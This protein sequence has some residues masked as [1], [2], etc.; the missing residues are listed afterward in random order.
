LGKAKI[1]G[2]GFCMFIVGTVFGILLASPEPAIDNGLHQDV[3][4]AIL[5]PVIDSGIP[6]FNT[7]LSVAEI[8]DNSIP[9][10][11]IT[12]H[13]K[14]ASCVYYNQL[15]HSNEDYV[16]KIIQFYGDV[17]N[18]YDDKFYF[19]WHTDKRII[20]NYDDS[21]SFVNPGDTLLFFGIVVG[22]DDIR[23]FSGKQ[24]VPEVKALIIKQI[25]YYD[26]GVK[27]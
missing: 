15:L 12:G 22:L 17:D 19:K 14:A 4:D 10:C 6:V 11:R 24:M 21:V 26:P 20:V 9:S 3:L 25:D 23:S 13:E 1:F 16:G 7:S 8:R 18:V 5:E 2:I 27:P